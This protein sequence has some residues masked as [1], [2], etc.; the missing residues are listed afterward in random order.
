MLLR[1]PKKH[2][3]TSNVCTFRSHGFSGSFDLSRIVFEHHFYSCVSLAVNDSILLVSHTIVYI[4]LS[5]M[6]LV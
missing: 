4:T 3:F 2:N 5:Q 6:K 1:P